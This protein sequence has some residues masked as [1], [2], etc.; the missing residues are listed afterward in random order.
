MPVD[1]LKAKEVATVISLARFLRLQLTGDTAREAHCIHRFTGGY[2]K[3]SQ[4]SHSRCHRLQNY[5]HQL[6]KS[7]FVCLHVTTSEPLNRFSYNFTLKYFLNYSTGLCTVVM[8]S[9]LK[10]SEDT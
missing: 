8:Q 6:T 2:E 10:N 4:F 1:V 7:V 5:P 9:N 3:R